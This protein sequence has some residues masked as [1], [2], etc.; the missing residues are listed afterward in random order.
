[1]KGD[2]IDLYSLFTGNSPKTAIAELSTPSIHITP[3]TRQ[4]AHKQPQIK[5]IPSNAN[6]KDYSSLFF[7]VIANQ[8]LPNSGREYLNK[9]GITD[10]LIL[11]Y[12][13]TGID[14]PR[15]FA[16]NLKAQY[17]LDDLLGS[18]LFDYSKNGKP[19][20]SFFYPAVIFPHWAMDFLRI[21]YLS[22]RNL[23]GDVK[24]F[25]LHNTHSQPFPGQ[26]AIGSKQIFIFEGIINGLSYEVLTKQENWIALCGLITPES[27]EALKLRFPNQKLILALDP[28]EAGKQALSRIESCT[29]INWTAF[30]AELGFKGLQ[31]HPNGKAWDLNDYLIATKR[32]KSQ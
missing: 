3:T 4:N 15:Q 29:Y 13:I 11:K 25:K 27:F 22:T 26:E 30:A 12:G 21:T 10:S 17:P 20:C 23:A 28:D 7:E 24:S 32:G 1:M 31:H 8:P 2:Q 19:Y 14:D 9:R 5:P 18:G 6:E 16:Y